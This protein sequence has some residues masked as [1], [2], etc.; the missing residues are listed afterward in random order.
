MIVFL[1]LVI[2]IAMFGFW[3]TLSALLGSL[4]MIVLF[5]AVTAGLVVLVGSLAWRW[6]KGRA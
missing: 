6:F 2:L 3:D 5:A 1:V 4:L